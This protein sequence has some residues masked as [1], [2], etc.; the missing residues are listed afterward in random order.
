MTP[1]AEHQDR[2]QPSGVVS[3]RTGL[4]L[5]L[6]RVWERRYKVVEPIRAPGGQRLYSDDDIVRLRLLHAATRGGR[7]IGQVAHLTTSELGA[8]V[9]ED[10]E[11][12]A[13]TQREAAGPPPG[14]V[15]LERAMERALELD[16]GELDVVLR[17]AMASLGLWEFA[18]GVVTPLLRA[19]GDGWHAGRITPAQEHLA[20]AAI[21]RVLLA[22]TDLLPRASGGGNMVVATPA[23]DRHEM[24]ALLV[25]AG[26]AIEGWQVTYLGSDLPVAEI[27]TAAARTDAR[28]VALSVSYITDREQIVQDLRSLRAQLSADV[29]L[30]V[31]GAAASDL[32]HDLAGTGIRVLADFAA[33]RTVLRGDQ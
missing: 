12:R 19:I 26:A 2:R 31:G 6:L 30:L 17:R 23:G 16:A 20:S 24:G 3:E 22:S 1:H 28:T 4:S 15:Y 33:L 25:A 11:G 9:T 8:L 5:D 21:R 29:G 7:S 18:E 27:A 13:H 32:A 10:E 14:E